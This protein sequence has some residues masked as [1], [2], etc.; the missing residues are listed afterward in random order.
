MIEWKWWD[1][2][3]LTKLEVVNEAVDMNVVRGG[4]ENPDLCSIFY[5]FPGY[6]LQTQKEIKIRIQKI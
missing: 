4:Q 5:R 3:N 6:N 1:S 2:F